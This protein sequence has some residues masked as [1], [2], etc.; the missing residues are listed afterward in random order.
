MQKPIFYHFRLVEVVEGGSLI[1]LAL[2]ILCRFERKKL[3]GGQ[4]PPGSFNHHEE[5][6]DRI[7]GDFLLTGFLAGNLGLFLPEVCQ[8]LK[9]VKKCGFSFH[10]IPWRGHLAFFSVL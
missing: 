10:F 7:F 1:I 9:L 3:P 4:P 6:F 2:Y 5:V 8:N